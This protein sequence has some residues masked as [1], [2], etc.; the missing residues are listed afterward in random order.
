MR[1]VAE[2]VETQD[3][4]ADDRGLVHRHARGRSDPLRTCAVESLLSILGSV[5]QPY[6]GRSQN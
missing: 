5:K 6:G 2:G 4:A 3:C 1:V